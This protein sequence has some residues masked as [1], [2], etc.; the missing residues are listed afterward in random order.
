MGGTEGARWWAEVDPA[1]T[2]AADTVNV[3]ESITSKA[4]GSEAN[5]RVVDISAHARS[6]SGEGQGSFGK[7]KKSGSGFLRGLG[8]KKKSSSSIGDEDNRDA[9]PQPGEDAASPAAYT[10]TE[11]AAKEKKKGMSGLLSLGRRRKSSGNLSEQA[12]ETSEPAPAA[13]PAGTERYVCAKEPLLFARIDRSLARSLHGRKIV[14]QAQRA[15]MSARRAGNAG[16]KMNTQHI[17]YLCVLCLLSLQ[18][19]GGAQEAS[20][21]T[22]GAR[23]ARSRQA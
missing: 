11:D 7:L 22:A 21:W 12:Y 18:L 13:D 4:S 2:A 8:R 10:Q 19:R 20:W 1:E 9:N 23:E 17:N 15:A 5:S 16:K 14:T 3:A 6:N